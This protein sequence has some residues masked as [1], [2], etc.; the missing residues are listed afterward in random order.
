MRSAG[1]TLNF[2]GKN[3]RYFRIIADTLNQ[4]AFRCDIPVQPH[5]AIA[6]ILFSH[7]SLYLIDFDRIGQPEL[8]ANG[9]SQSSTPD[10]CR[11]RLHF[12]QY[13]SDSGQNECLRPTPTPVTAP[14]AQLCPEQ[15]SDATEKG[16]NHRIGR[17]SRNF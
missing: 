17:L 15:L 8:P 4:A 10:R 1:Q 9:N 14:T 5:L 12:T 16:I 13:S 7:S 2:I 6:T 3:D 11:I